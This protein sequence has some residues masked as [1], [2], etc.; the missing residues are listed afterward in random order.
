MNR[1]LLLSFAAFAAMAC[2]F[3]SSVAVAAPPASKSSGGKKA[4]SALVVKDLPKLG[5]AV[6]VR[7]PEFD[8][9]VKAPSHRKSDARWAQFEVEYDT[10]PDWIDEATFNFYVML[11]E[12]KTKLWHFFQTSV[13]YLDIA[14]GAHGAAVYLPPSAVARYGEAKFFRV[15]ITID[16]EVV[17]KKDVGSEGWVEQMGQLGD[18]VARHSGYLQDRSK[19]PFGLTYVDDYEAVR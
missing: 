7:A 16:G 1:N 2:I 15:E 18:R 12:P 19:T 14:K 10:T 8:G 9:K 4:A 17:A 11:Q 13:T 5:K 6:L 3:S